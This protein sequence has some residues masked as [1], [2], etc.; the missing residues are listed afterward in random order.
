M[1]YKNPPERTRWKK[2]QSGNP[3]GPTPKLPSLDKLMA[4]ALGQEVKGVT[5]ADAILYALI[6]KAAKGDVKAAEMLFNRGYG[7]PKET[8]A[9]QLLDA[10]GN[11]VDT[12][13]NTFI[14]TLD[15]GK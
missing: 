4:H 10:E 1:A 14:I 15:L 7:K 11:P 6:T 3:K 13:G 5:A 8:I 2:G 12:P 9:N